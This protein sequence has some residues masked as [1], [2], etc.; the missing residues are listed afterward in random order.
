MQNKD[1]KTL[2]EAECMDFLRGEVCYYLI[3]DVS[4]MRHYLK[5]FDDL[6]TWTVSH[7]D[8]SKTLWYRQENGMQ[9]IS[10]AYEITLD[11]PV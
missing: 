7:Q 1:G 2:T 3:N 11:H 6:S 8:S 5:V 10:I 9:L 4:M